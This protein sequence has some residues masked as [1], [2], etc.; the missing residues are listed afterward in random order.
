PGHSPLTGWLPPSSSPS[1]A[2]SRTWSVS[3]S[4]SCEACSRKAASASW[5]SGNRLVPGTKWC[6]PLALREAPFLCLQLLAQE[7][8]LVTEPA[9][10][11]D[12]SPAAA[13]IEVFDKS[14]GS[15]MA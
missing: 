13:A 7:H 4:V 6:L 15:L 10:A 1:K 11:H 8:L 2:T 14:S 5:T 3:T 12:M 9:L